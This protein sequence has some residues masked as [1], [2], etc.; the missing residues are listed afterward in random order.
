[1][2]IVHP[3]SKL[4]KFSGIR[5]TMVVRVNFLYSYTTDRIDELG[6]ITIIKNFYFS[7]INSL[8]RDGVLRLTGS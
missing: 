4:L 5:V 8:I 2:L 6:T 1:M 3:Y 7:F